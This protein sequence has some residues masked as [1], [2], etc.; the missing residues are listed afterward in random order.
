[1]A[2]GGGGVGVGVDVGVG[3]A[4]GG[5]GVGA[6]VDVGA[7]GGAAPGDPTVIVAVAESTCPVLSDTRTQY[8][9]V[10]VSAGVVKFSVVAPEI[11]APVLPLVPTYH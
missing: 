4:P 5:A 1:V 9:V 11:G 2:P 10:C 7:G 6:G 8:S 3:V